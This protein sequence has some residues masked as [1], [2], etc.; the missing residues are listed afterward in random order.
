MKVV[1]A[2]TCLAATVT[3]ANAEVFQGVEMLPGPP[4]V[5]AG[6]AEFMEDGWQVGTKV[7]TV[8]AVHE[9]CPAGL[10]DGEL[11][12]IVLE[13]RRSYKDDWMFQQ[14]YKMAWVSTEVDLRSGSEDAC[15][16]ALIKLEGQ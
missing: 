16:R 5:T 4:Q 12:S 6:G 14:A 3:V 2:I 15:R 7:G 11:R 1:V 10:V 13:A 8:L 9:N